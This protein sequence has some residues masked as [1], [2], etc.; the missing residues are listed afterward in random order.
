MC[1]KVRNKSIFEVGK[2]THWLCLS[3]IAVLLFLLP[4]LE[5]L[6]DSEIIKN[7]LKALFNPQDDTGIKHC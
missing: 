5:H 6:L 7:T 3:L 2:A 4:L 1:N